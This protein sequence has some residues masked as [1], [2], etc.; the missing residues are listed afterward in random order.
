M[1][2]NVYAVYDSK[3]Q[4]YLQPW[5]CQNHNVAFR[6]MEL[7]L[8]NPQCPFKQFP[9]DFT[10]FCIG[11]F[12]DL[13]GAITGHAAHESLGNMIQFAPAP[14]SEEAEPGLPFQPHQLMP[15]SSQ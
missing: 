6:N 13:T 7:A 8:R 14:G 5:F 10:L 15:A 12:D 1:L 9:A 11:E 3:A 2:V 4:A